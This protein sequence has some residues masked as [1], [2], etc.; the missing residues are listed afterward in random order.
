MYGLNMV[1]G[2]KGMGKTSFLVYQ[3]WQAYFINGSR[4]KRRS[5]ELI[6]KINK[7]YDNELTAPLDVPIFTSP[8]LK[9]KFPIGWYEY[10]EPYMVNPYYIG[11]NDNSGNPIMFLPPASTVIIPELQRVLNSRKSASF[12][13]RL[14]Q[15]FEESR[16]WDIT[17]WGDGQRGHLMDLNF[18]AIT[19]RIYE[20]QGVEDEKD[21][22]GRTIKTTWHCREFTKL[23]Y[24]DEYVNGNGTN[25]EE[26]MY[27]YKGNIFRF[28][29]SKQCKEDYIPPKG[30]DFKYLKHLGSKEIIQLPQE[31]AALYQ[32]S[33][34]KW[35]RSN[36][37]ET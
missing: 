22:L 34:P 17:F 3:A 23:K 26:T 30:T 28:Y 9:L 10:Y 24:Y 2:N 1:V 21:K 32:L 35:F 36:K 37:S 8:K 33:E 5:A 4:L 19:D 27:S 29:D 11:T 16:H 15:W 14:S 25:Y 12:P 20:M 13:D 6:A 18:R 7:D 31:E